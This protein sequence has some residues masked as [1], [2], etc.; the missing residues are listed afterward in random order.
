MRKNG[1]EDDERIP[2]Y[3][4]PLLCLPA[5]VLCAGN[6]NDNAEDYSAAG[7]EGES[8]SGEGGRKHSLQG[9]CPHPSCDTFSPVAC[10]FSTI[11]N[12]SF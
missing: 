12:R 4:S 8:C 2:P 6:G 7:Q 9:K 3:I 10:V 11:I 1:V 5:I